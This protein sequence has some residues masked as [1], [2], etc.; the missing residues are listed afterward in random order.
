MSSGAREGV[1]A[2]ARRFWQV[3]PGDPNLL[4]TAGSFS[5]GVGDNIEVDRV[6][7]YYID[8]SLKA[9]E[10][11][12]PPDWLEE[13]DQQLHVATAQYG[14]GCYERYLSGEGDE[15]GQAALATADYLLADQAGDGSWVH[16]MPMPHTYW[17]Q[18]PWISG[19]A[20]G[21]G[22]SLFVRAHALSGDDRYAEAAIKALAPMRIPTSRGGVRAEIDGGLFLEEY[23]TDPASLVLNGAIFALWGCRDVAIGLG[24]AG[25]AE[26]HEEAL[27]TLAANIDRFDT[28]F[29]SLYDLFPHPIRNIA[30]GAYHRLHLN[31]LRALQLISPRPQFG[32]AIER[33]ERYEGSPAC[34]TR[35]LTQKIAFRVAVPRNPRLALRLPWSHR[36]V[37][38]EVL[39]LCYHAV[40]DAWPSRLAVSR[41]QLREQLQYLVDR[42]YEGVT[43]SEAVTRAGN[44][45]PRLAVTFDDGYAS[46]EANA[47]P[48]LAELGLPG[49]VFVPTSYVGSAEP[50]AWP[51]I[52]QW[53]GTPHRHELAPLDWDG[54]A[55]LAAA[56]W[57][58]GS[59]SHTHPRLTELDDAALAAE[60]S[61]SR[62]EL[63]RRLQ[64]PCRS[65][66]Y[67]YGDLDERVID[68]A[69][70]AGYVAGAALPPRFYIPR[71]LAWPRLGIYRR[72]R[73][74]RF[75]GKT[76]RIVR[77]LR[78]N[79]VW[80]VATSVA[81]RARGLI[82]RDR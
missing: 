28:G 78:R 40:S 2:R 59:H 56:G 21:E 75:R 68:A 79:F 10:P 42:G 36:P 52:D 41:S 35:A 30:S 51:G 38:G 77:A 44:G 72:D 54:V 32:A 5:P 62:L 25:A 39:V 37:H 3:H 9:D 63:E 17:I 23:P 24:D 70:D 22:A 65:I 12:W 33:F 61:Q 1:V 31:Q 43:F 4:S 82:R 81:R 14:L 76:S 74:S 71:P 47:V 18:P 53:L 64:A 67:P 7:G 27:A 80:P 13:R 58:I 48:I 15:W 57:E 16:R 11:V 29:W 8:M 66:A 50:M 45:N 73:L 55:R 20:Q 34:R 60:L 49:T 19:M 26:L 46:L 69:R 6:H